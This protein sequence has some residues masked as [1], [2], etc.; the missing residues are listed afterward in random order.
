MATRPIIF[1]ALSNELPPPPQFVLHLFEQCTWVSCTIGRPFEP[2]WVA[3]PIVPSQQV[4]LRVQHTHFDQR[5]PDEP[6]RHGT[7]DM[8]R[9]TASNF[10]VPI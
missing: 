10:R 8:S 4:D 9:L 7:E 3:S 6:E 1:S 2:K 5:L